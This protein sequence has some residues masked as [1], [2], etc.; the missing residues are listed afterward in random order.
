MA[1][2]IRAAMFLAVLAAWGAA[3]CRA[4]ALDF[5]LFNIAKDPRETHDKAEIEP[6][7]TTLLRRKLRNYLE[8]SEPIEMQNHQAI[9]QASNQCG[10]A[11]CIPNINSADA[12]PV[13]PR[14]FNTTGAPNVVFLLFDDL[15]WNEVG[16]GG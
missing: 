12:P 2:S 8:I 4:T 7:V 1:Q 14:K 10:G 15:G 11:S 3:V 9:W 13:I 5:N 16:S 6:E